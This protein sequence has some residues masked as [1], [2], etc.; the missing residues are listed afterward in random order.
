MI[1]QKIKNQR[2]INLID[3][4][5][6]LSSLEYIIK[7]NCS[8]ESLQIS[9]I[10]A[11]I[12]QNKTEAT[13]VYNL[14][15]KLF[16]FDF[17]DLHTKEHLVKNNILKLYPLLPFLENKSLDSISQ[18]LFSNRETD[19]LKKE[20]K[21]KIKTYGTVTLN[22]IGI[23]TLVCPRPKNIYDLLKLNHEKIIPIRVYLILQKNLLKLNWLT[24][25]YTTEELFNFLCSMDYEDFL[26]GCFD[27][28]AT[29]KSRGIDELNLKM[30]IGKKIKTI[31]ELH[32]K[33]MF[34]VE[35]H[36]PDNRFILL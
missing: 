26:E 32:N 23:L 9:Y 21:N 8:D 12:D 13:Y 14:S 4:T 3:C 18:I 5:V 33:L 17:L 34:T 31:R 20:L 36:Y 24:I 6:E 15:P 35:G 30:I 29:L 27:L 28:I 25:L 16:R 1:I 22:N 10:N 7:N 19:Y 11:L 2:L